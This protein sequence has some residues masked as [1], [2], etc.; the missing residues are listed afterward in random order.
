MRRLSGVLVLASFG[1]VVGCGDDGMNNATATSTA[2]TM[3]T[4]PPLTTGM[5][6]GTGT[7]TDTSEPTS[8]EG[9]GSSSGTATS[10]PTTG[11]TDTTGPV[12]TTAGPTSDT[13]TSSTTDN[14]TMGSTT[15][16]PCQE[17][18]VTLQPVKPNTMLVLDKSGSMKNFTWDHDADP[19]TPNVTRW[20]SLYAVVEQI[21]TNFNDSFNF[22]MNLFP[23]KSATDAYTQA[24][25][26]VSNNVEVA[27]A[28]MNKD[29]IIAALPPQNTMSILGGTPTAK[30][31]TSALT[32]LKTLDP[33]N[34]RVVILV[35][36]GAANCSTSAQNVNDLFEVYDANLAG[37]VGDAW[38]VD[39]IPTYVIGIAIQND[40]TPNVGDG[41]PNGINPHEKLNELAM[42]GGK[43]K[44]G[45]EAFYSAGN[46]IELADALNA[47]VSD[48]FSCVIP[49]ESP[50]AFPNSTVVKIGGVE[51]P[52]VADCAMGNGWKYVD[53]EPYMAIEI[54]GTACDDLKVAGD[55]D[56]EYYCKAG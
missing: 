15:D 33:A 46:Q 35:T 41:N 14:M 53:P 44:A 17:L 20:F 43:P 50:P 2:T 38:T 27:V 19:M 29:P 32:H 9:T 4:L 51:V 25:C 40:I 49:L 22:G 34:P 30:G 48:A 24:A 8:S 18:M 52:Q 16:T 55:A 31:M 13:M 28:E 42:L 45:P 26:P 54:C 3:S 7:G 5:S 56:V 39:Q 37:I 36:D 1:L 47:I 11:S 23:S 21:L 12:M 6:T 10:E